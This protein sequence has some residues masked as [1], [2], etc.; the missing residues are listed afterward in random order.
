MEVLHIIKMRIYINIRDDFA[1][2]I[3]TI[4]DKVI[5]NGMTLGDT[6]YLKQFMRIGVNDPGT[7]AEVKQASRLIFGL[8]ILLADG[9][10]IESQGPRSHALFIKRECRRLNYKFEVL[11]GSL[12]D[13]KCLV[14]T[15]PK[16][17]ITYPDEQII[18]IEA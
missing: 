3:T 13:K 4:N 15:D 17:G 5:H 10:P 12:K 9:R 11:E 6:C 7:I 16:T 1:S 8:L 18:R 2:I 14:W